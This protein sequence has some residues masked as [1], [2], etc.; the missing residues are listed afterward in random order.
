M[1]FVLG[2]YTDRLNQLEQELAFQMEEA[3]TKRES[4]ERL[5]KFL[6]E[7]GYESALEIAAEFTRTESLVILKR[8]E[9]RELREAHEART[10]FSD[11]LRQELRRL[12]ADV[13][14]REAAL[15]DTDEFI[16]NEKELRAELLSAKFR[17]R[18]L[19]SASSI[20]G[21]VDF[22]S[23]PRCGT[24]LNTL[25]QLDDNCRLCGSSN[26]ASKRENAAPRNANQTD[27]DARLA[28][29]DQSLSFRQKS[30]RQQ[31][32]E[33]ED[34]VS[35]KATSDLR[36]TQEMRTY[37]SAFLSQ[38]RALER[39]IASL[40]QELN[41]LRRDAR[42]PEALNLM[43][44]EADQH[45]AK[46]TELRREIALERQKLSSNDQLVHILEQYFFEALEAAGFP[47]LVSGDEIFVNRRNW[48]A[49]IRPG[50]DESIDYDF[51][52]AGSGGK[53][54]C[55]KF[56]MRSLCID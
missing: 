38:A 12:A 29:I 21:N 42:I 7:L 9:L 35:Q 47:S 22:D 1:R 19:E 40:E 32:R 36:L 14:S 17:L 5:R 27:L 16:R 31:V 18:R 10:H 3:R 24:D 15:A 55:S 30:R 6:G 43:E 8:E 45:I 37:D 51:Q 54:P 39:Q 34:R 2:Y 50:G 49:Y 25:V 48:L 28:E 46:A 26:G 44:I 56:V 41:T 53:K 52:G 20:L 33:L 4:A 13:A 11:D 23:C